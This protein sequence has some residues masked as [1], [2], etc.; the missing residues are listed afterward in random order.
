MAIN[1]EIKARVADLEALRKQAEDLAQRPVQVLNQEDVFF[2]IPKGRLKLRME[3]ND[4]GQLIYYDRPDEDGPKASNYQI[5][6]TAAPHQLRALLAASLGE[7]GVVKKTRS[8]Y[9]VGQ[10]RI[11]LDEVEGLGSYME[12]EVVLADGQSLLEG[13]SVARDLCAALSIT[14]ANLVRGAY[15]DLLEAQGS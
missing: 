14:A 10:T 11:H 6:P 8:L 4:R 12:L 15:I 9:W 2:N 7:R 5:Y 3:G 13:E 1:I